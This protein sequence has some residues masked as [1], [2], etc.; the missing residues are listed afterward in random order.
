M[1]LSVSKSKPDN[2]LYDLPIQKAQPWLCFFFLPSDVFSQETQNTLFLFR[3]NL[4]LI[5][6]IIL[7]CRLIGCMFFC[8]LFN[9]MHGYG[10]EINRCIQFLNLFE[11]YAQFPGIISN[12]FAIIVDTGRI[13]NLIR[14]NTD[15]TIA[16]RW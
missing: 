12:R 6:S 1:S 11:T 9:K 7:A 4:L 3:G 2:L 5:G 15:E 13:Y 8:C 14:A 16:A 10:I